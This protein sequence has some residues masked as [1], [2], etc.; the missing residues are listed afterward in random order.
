MESADKQG[1]VLGGSLFGGNAIEESDAVSRDLSG[2]IEIVHEKGETE[3]GRGGRG[4]QPE[5]FP[6]D[7]DGVGRA[8]V[9][10]GK[11]AGNIGAQGVCGKSRG[12]GAMQKN[13]GMAAIGRRGGGPL[14][15]AVSAERIAVAITGKTGFPSFSV[16]QIDCELNRIACPSSLWF[17][18]ESGLSVFFVENID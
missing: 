12:A 16:V 8:I 9:R 7:F 3:D 5:F 2:G 6:R 13:G 11:R 17:F 14:E 15:D 4:A 10:A 18:G 1:A